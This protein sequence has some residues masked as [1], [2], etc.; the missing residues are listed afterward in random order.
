MNVTVLLVHGAMNTP[1]IWKPVQERLTAQGIAS[2][3][4]QLPSSHPDSRAV[5]DIEADV[6]VL[7]A[8]IEAAP[9]PVVLAA[10]SYG[11]VPATWVAG[12]TAKVIEIVYMAAFLL[13]PGRSILDWLGGAFPDTWEFSSDGRAM[14]FGDVENN[15]LNGVDPALATEVIKQLSW[16]SVQAFHQPLPTTP[17]ETKATYIITTQDRALPPPAQEAMAA[18]TTRTVRVAS[19][20][21]PHLACP[22]EVVAV[23]A[24]AVA[25]AGT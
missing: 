9:G 22:D 20:H 2:M 23:L 17:T 11:G 10:N 25:R 18:R 7:R 14:K 3:A 1:W 15:L 5:Q 24:G 19:G 6:A 8:A 13:E 12:E 16:V 4:V 21:Y